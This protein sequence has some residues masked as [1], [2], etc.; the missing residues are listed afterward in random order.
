MEGFGVFTWA[1]GRKY[2]GNL[3]NDKFEGVA[4]YTFTTG[5]TKIGKY[6]DGKV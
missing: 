5:N 4:R 2:E 1:D 6:S 3:L